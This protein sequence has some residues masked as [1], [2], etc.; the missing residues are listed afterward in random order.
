MEIHSL[1]NI[2][3]K[4]FILSV[5]NSK[6]FYYIPLTSMVT[7]IRS[8]SVSLSHAF[9]CSIHHKEKYVTHSN[10]S[11]NYKKYFINKLFYSL[12]K[13]LKIKTPGE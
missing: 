9:L 8:S 2:K 1:F 7:E 4:L 6:F 3:K 5:T 10:D 13:S 11:K 12:N